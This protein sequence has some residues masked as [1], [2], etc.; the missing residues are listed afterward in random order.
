MHLAFAAEDAPRSEAGASKHDSQSYPKINDGSLATT[1]SKVTTQLS[2]T[3]RFYA[4]GARNSPVMLFLNRCTLLL[5]RVFFVGE[6]HSTFISTSLQAS[7]CLWSLCFIYLNCISVCLYFFFSV[8]LS[9]CL[10]VCLSI[11]LYCL[12]SL[13]FRLYVCHYLPVSLS[14]CLRL[15]ISMCI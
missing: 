7:F 3:T 13:I 9:F 11:G 14:I 4:V 6:F 8:S 5:V 2:F 15:S 10:L 12:I 1:E